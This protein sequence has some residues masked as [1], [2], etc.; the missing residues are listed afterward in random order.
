MSGLVPDLRKLID[1]FQTEMFPKLPKPV[2]EPLMRGIDDLVL[3]G[4]DRAALRVGDRAPDFELPDANG[5]PVR[6]SRLL[7]SGPVVLSFYRGVW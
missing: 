2:L 4:I 6:L 3:A 7:P 1:D 5:T